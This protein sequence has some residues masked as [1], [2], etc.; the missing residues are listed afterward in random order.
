MQ[1]MQ[2]RS[3]HLTFSAIVRVRYYFH[4]HHYHHVIR[5]AR[6]HL[7]QTMLLDNCMHPA[8]PTAQTTAVHLP[9]VWAAYTLLPPSNRNT[10]DVHVSVSCT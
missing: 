3:S 8:L 6:A 5:P 4:H 9:G 10:H 7:S 1:D 2:R